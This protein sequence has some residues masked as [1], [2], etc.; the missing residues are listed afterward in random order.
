MKK[1]NKAKKSLKGQMTVEMT[2]ILIALVG[3]VGFATERFKEYEVLQNFITTPWKVV[4]HMME[5][6]VWE[7]DRE[8]AKLQHPGHFRRMY[9]HK[10]GSPR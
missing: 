9:G 4:S 8:T 3:L 7:K 1:N 10:G 6:G 2:L 5:F